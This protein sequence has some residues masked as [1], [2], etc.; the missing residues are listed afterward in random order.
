[1]TFKS[2][3]EVLSYGAFALCAA[4]IPPSIA[5]P[6]AAQASNSAYW[7]LAQETHNYIV[8]NLLT[9]YGSYEIQPGSNTSYAWYDGSQISADAEFVLAGDNRYIPY[10]NNTY[11][12]MGNLWDIG[13]PNGGYFAAANVDGTN[14]GGGQYVDDNSLIAL[15]YLD[16]YEV[17]SGTFQA[18][19]LA[20]AEACA[21][22]LINSGQW[23]STYG[24]GFWWNTDKQLKPTQSN[25]LA[26]QLFLRLYKITGN[27]L[28]RTWA[29]KVDKWLNDVMFDRS[30]G[31]YI[32]QI[33]DGI[34]QTTNF[35]YDNAI[36]IDAEL[37]YAEILPNHGYISKAE[38]LAASLSNVL[39]NEPSGVYAL[40]TGSALVNPTWSG[41]ATL[42]LLHLYKVAPKPVYLD[43][44]RRNVDFM[45]A[46]LR[47]SLDGGYY[48][49]CNTDGTNLDTTDI[50]SVDQA[51][52]QRL[53]ALLSTYGQ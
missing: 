27:T 18:Q 53:Q 33:Q 24:G 8:G 32:W 43:H 10:M 46:N 2:I 28:Y 23:D 52:M 47:N 21:N 3:G 34:K 45:N 17:S 9:I 1:M 35:T 38:K 50:E 6:A 40:N 41:W 42:S 48:R 20:S 44:A 36:M 7:N 15:A 5:I 25:G 13:S 22:W 31:L 11:G 4:I 29:V 49:F 39:W 12:W 30:N 19:Y 51:W 16:A 14:A 26:L 37:L